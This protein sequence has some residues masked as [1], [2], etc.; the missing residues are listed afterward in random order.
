MQPRSVSFAFAA[1]LLVCQLAGAQTWTPLAHQPSFQASTALLLTDGTVM[2]QVYGTGQWWRLAP[3]NSGSYV[4]G[5]WSQ[6]ATMPSGYGPLYYGSAVL[7]D[8][9]VM[10]Q[11]G[12]YNFGTKDWINKGAIYNPATNAWTSVN[13]PSGW[14]EIGDAQSAVLANGTFMLADPFNVNTA[15]LNAATLTWTVSGSSTGK[16]D[17]NDEEGWTLLPSGKVLTVDANNYSNLT[18]S[19]LYNP[20]TGLWSTAGSTIVQLDDTT[21]SGGGSHEVGPAVLRPDG[22]VFATGG[23]G[24]TA[25]YNSVSG[26]WSVGPMFSSGLDIA[27][28]P[29]A[30]LPD[31]NVLVDASPG[32]F[33]PPSHFYEFNGSSLISVPGP[34]N[35][36]IDSSFQGRMLLLPTGQVLFTDGSGDV[37]IYT[38]TGTYQ[39]AWRPSI[40]SVASTLNPGSTS[41][42]ISGK[43]FNGLSQANAYGDDAQEA[44]NYPLVRITNNVSLHVSYCKTH[45]HS[46]MGVATG[47]ATVSTQFDV[48]A[49]IE[50]GASTIA[51]V[52][53]GIPSSP[54]SVNIPE[55]MNDNVILGS[56]SGDGASSTFEKYNDSGTR[57]STGNLSIPRSNHTATRL[58]TTG[59]IF[60]AGGVQDT[61]SWQILDVNA[62]VVSSGLLNDQRSSAAADRL[63]NGNVFLAGGIPVPGTWEIHSPTG[64]LV[65]SGNLFATHSGGHSV[66]A[67]QN[68]NVWISGSNVANGSPSEWEIRS[69]S[70]AFVSTGNLVSAREGAPTVLLPSGNVMIIGGDGD[71]GSYEIHSQTGALVSTSTLFN[72]FASGS[73]AVVLANG[74]VFILGSG[75]WEIRTGTGSFVSTGSLFNPRAGAGAV[76]V[77]TGNVFIT[78]G[79][80]APAT[81]EIRNSS[82]ALVSQGNLFNT[83]YPGHTLTH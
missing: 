68:G 80:S 44:T 3:D 48:P 41:N 21:S 29:A 16:A 54:V 20:A 27:D 69:A 83:R 81:W 77:S 33:Q 22:T 40:T 26:T 60:V 78:G 73:N 82:G 79:S 4:N 42:A 47:T 70:G 58:P 32:V 13:P 65:G 53:N 14:T 12:E 39:S 9:R 56:E 11:G 38:P 67:L 55:P 1:L 35:A 34:P 30:L 49:G 2:V 71:P 28:G 62:N 76:V 5:S 59:N 19:E 57:L 10:I 64:T 36:S 61:T 18:N 6:L 23:T 72:A 74:N 37:E 52:A 46:T 25:I 15:Q 66:V 51:V 8:G 43:Q 24:N 7:S 17:A 45:N 50:L 63:T 75:T 31:A